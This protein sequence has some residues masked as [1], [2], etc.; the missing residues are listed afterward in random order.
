[1]GQAQVTRPPSEG[2]KLP[3]SKPQKQ[4]RRHDAQARGGRKHTV[5]SAWVVRVYELRRWEVGDVSVRRRNLD[6]L[7][8]AGVGG[9]RRG[10]LDLRANH[11]GLIFFF[12]PV[13]RKF[14][15]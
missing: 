7:T 10:M 2:A 3:D 11:D 8:D 12:A 5:G 1:M 4:V 13:V 9:T 14:N 6:K 15:G